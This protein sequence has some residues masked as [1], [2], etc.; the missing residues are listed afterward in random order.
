M[1]RASQ[2][3]ITRILLACGVSAGPLFVIAF[4]V[5]GATRAG[6]NSLRHPVSGYPPGSSPLPVEPTWHGLAHDLVS[7]PGFL[8]L[9]L[10]CFA[11][12]RTS[13]TG[14]A[15]G[16]ASCGTAFVVLFLLASAGFSQVDVLVGFAGLFQRATAIIGQAWLCALAIHCLRT[17]TGD[18]WNSGSLL[19]R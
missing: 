9:T 15:I 1:R 12:A 16:S 8:A 2:H 13:R 14:W 6:Y 5:E 18:P 7:I 10:A 19:T 4:V 3:R 11:L 17:H